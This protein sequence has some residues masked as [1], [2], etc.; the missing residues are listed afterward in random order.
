MAKDIDVLVPQI[1]FEHLLKIK[2]ACRYVP[3]D[4]TARALMASSRGEGCGGESWGVRGAR[5]VRA[6]CPGVPQLVQVVHL[7]F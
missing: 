2:P 3:V 6:H 1:T 4:P 5:R 7:R